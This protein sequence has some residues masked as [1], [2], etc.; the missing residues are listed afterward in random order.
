MV[1]RAVHRHKERCPLY[2][3]YRPARLRRGAWA[4]ESRTSWTSWS[5][6]RPPPEKRNNVPRPVV[7][8]GPPKVGFKGVLEPQMSMIEVLERY[9]PCPSAV[10]EGTGTT[11]SSRPSSTSKIASRVPVYY[12]PSEDV[13]GSLVT[14][15]ANRIWQVARSCRNTNS[16]NDSVFLHRLPIR[17]CYENFRS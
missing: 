6:D 1:Q 9:A 7:I 11:T 2:P 4:Q 14:R 17:H 8:P 12:P 5:G 13:A 10:P 3:H 15:D 16:K